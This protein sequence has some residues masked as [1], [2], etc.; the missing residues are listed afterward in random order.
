MTAIFRSSLYKRNIREEHKLGNY[1]QFQNDH[2]MKFVKSR[3]R[4]YYKVKNCLD[5]LEIIIE[6][7]K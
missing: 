5:V 1:V 6:S 2:N 7:K 3:G 4:K